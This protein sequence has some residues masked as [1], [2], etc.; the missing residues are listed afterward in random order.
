MGIR[1][2]NFSSMSPLEKLKAVLAAFVCFGIFAPNARASKETVV[3]ATKYGDVK[4]VTIHFPHA[5]GPVKAINKFLGVPYASAPVGALRFH[6]PCEPKP[7]KPDIYDATHFHSVCM[8]QPALFMNAIQNVW[9]DFTEKDFSEDCL[10]LNI[11]VPN[12]LPSLNGTTERQAAGRYPVMVYFHGGSYFAGTPVRLETPGEILPLRGVV[13]VTVQY[14][15]GAFGFL[16]T[17]DAAAPGN[18]GIL[19][20]VQS[21]K[22][23]KENIHGFNGDPKNVTIFGES[24]GGASVGLHTV[25]PL[26]KG[27]FQRAIAD[28]GVDFSPFAYLPLAKV[29]N[30]TRQLA[31]NLGCSLKS[32]RI[33]TECLRNIDA[34]K[35]AKGASNTNQFYPV[36]DN[37]FLPQTPQVLRRQGKSHNVALLAGY[38]KDDAGFLLNDNDRLEPVS[39]RRAYIKNT[40]IKGNLGWKDEKTAQYLAAAIEFQYTPWPHNK[41]L[42]KLR[43]KFIEMY[44]DYF[45][46]APTHAVLQQHALNSRVFMY[47]FRYRS[48]NDKTPSWRGVTHGSNSKYIFGVPFLKLFNTSSVQEFDERDRNLSNFV[49]TLYTNFAKYGHPTPRSV[50]G[51]KWKPFNLADYAYIRIDEKPVMATK[52]HPHR[53]AFWNYY[54]PHFVN[55][56]SDN[57]VKPDPGPEQKEGPVIGAVNNEAG[58]FLLCGSLA[59]TVA[60]LW[61]LK[62]LL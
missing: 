8:Q 22:W 30:F 28:S 42:Q 46:S 10:F 6:K 33:M 43:R 11:Y 52:F 54:Y 58:M 57:H 12:S 24:A 1:Q 38:T 16:T 15:L 29:I 17:G 13:L 5:S 26:S 37:Y 44:T 3:A 50:G 34:F 36:V 47:E 23:I 39:H 20:Q 48:K 41:D 56:T 32:N 51:V 49:M 35:I 14:R 21:L 40:V 55:L 18:A 27:L 59:R 19:D 4:G 9:P 7:W 62:R 53:I 60:I 45:L 61:G 31:Q 25:S 2:T